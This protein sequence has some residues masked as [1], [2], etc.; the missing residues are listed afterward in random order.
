[1]NAALVLQIITAAMQLIPL[2]VG[3]YQG[4]KELL[5]ADPAIPEELKKILLDT[6]IDN[7][8]TLAAVQ[9]WVAANPE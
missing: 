6:S 2:G 1:M 3:T 5:A 8:A 4:I 9:A 7:A